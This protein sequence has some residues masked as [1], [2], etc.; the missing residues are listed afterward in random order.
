MMNL[1][2]EYSDKTGSTLNRKAFVTYPGPPVVLNFSVEFIQNII[3]SAQTELGFL[4]VDYN[5]DHSTVQGMKDQ[6]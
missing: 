2:Q 1:A 6:V 5:E 3:Y 4:P